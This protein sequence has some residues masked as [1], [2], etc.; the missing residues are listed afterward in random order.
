GELLMNI[1]PP[2]SL[3][4]QRP[5]WSSDG[6]TVTVVTLSD[7]GEGI[8]SYSPTGKR[9]TVHMEENITD[10]VQAK[11]HNDTLFY[12]AQGDGSDNIYR[13]AGDG[14]AERITGSRFGIS[15]F[16]VRGGELLFSDYSAG[17][18]I[19]ASEKTSATA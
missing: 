14:P 2:D 1:V 19:I 18:Y 4:L 17:G 12:L 7:K 8:R 13:T 15:G 3:M 9:W 16:S 6:S 11:I 10:I 5:A